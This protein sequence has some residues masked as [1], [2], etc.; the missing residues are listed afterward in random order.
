MVVVA[1]FGCATT[2]SVVV[3]ECAVEIALV[4]HSLAITIVSF[5]SLTLVTQPHL[6]R[7]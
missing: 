1:G 7:V 4:V 2:S 6:A 5:A 3:A